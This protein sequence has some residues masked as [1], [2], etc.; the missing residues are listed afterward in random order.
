MPG[1]ADG[2]K[3]QA[4]ERPKTWRLVGEAEDGQK[5][6]IVFSLQGSLLDKDLPPILTKPRI[7]N[8]RYKYLRQSIKLAGLGTT[9]FS[10]ALC[11]IGEI[12]GYFDRH[13]PQGALECWT[14][15]AS[16]GVGND[17]LEASNRYMSPKNESQDDEVPFGNLVDPKRVLEKMAQE[18]RHIHTD[19][20][21]V[22]Y[23][24][25]RTTEDGKTTHEKV[26]PQMFRIGDIIEIQVSFVV[27]PL[28]GDRYK[29]ITVLRSIALING[30]F[31]QK[32]PG[33]KIHVAPQTSN[34]VLKRKVMYDEVDDNEGTQGTPKSKSSLTIASMQPKHFTMFHVIAPASTQINLEE[35]LQTV[36]AGQCTK[37]AC[38]VLR[39]KKGFTDKE[40]WAMLAKEHCAG[41]GKANSLRNTRWCNNCRAMGYCDKDC[42]GKHWSAH[43]PV[44]KDV[45]GESSTPVEDMLFRWNQQYAWDLAGMYCVLAHMNT[46]LPRSIEHLTTSRGVLRVL[47]TSKT[48]GKPASSYHELKFLRCDII[49]RTHPYL[50][51]LSAKLDA[52]EKKIN[53]LYRNDDPSVPHDTLWA[54][55]LLVNV[56]DVE[57]FPN[58]EDTVICSTIVLNQIPKNELARSR[59]G[60]QTRITIDDAQML[61]EAHMKDDDKA[62]EE[63][64]RRRGAG[65]STEKKGTDKAA[66][67][68]EDRARR[69]HRNK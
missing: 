1:W 45:R 24:R 9:A 36:K 37:T 67:D 56:H 63:R 42:Q 59:D 30:A 58:T 65:P 31:S 61:F 69:H 7:A 35:W 47:V 11:S 33:T 17:V 19:D 32:A 8:A 62:Y 15:T 40:I 41:C 44:C 10:A 5:E 60:Y 55:Q 29:M 52:S 43:A 51:S 22:M 3:V 53:E 23:F 49:D 2:I 28:K 26:G 6:E 57:R 25:R 46:G 34:S 4:M 13:F 48:A 20:N 27:V 38:M 12:Y 18:S 66:E 21:E 16:D 64:Q 68:Y 39:V 50:T 14:A 54:F